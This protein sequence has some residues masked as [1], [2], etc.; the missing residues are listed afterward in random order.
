LEF[1]LFASAIGKDRCFVVVP[2]DVPVESIAPTPSTKRAATKLPSDYLGYNFVAYDVSK[3]KSNEL[4][5]NLSEACAELGGQIQRKKGLGKNQFKGL[6]GN[7]KNAVFVLPDIVAGRIKTSG[8]NP[9]LVSVE[10]RV[11]S[12]DPRTNYRQSWWF[13]WDRKRRTRRVLDNRSEV[14]KNREES[15]VHANDQRAVTAISMVLAKYGVDLLT[16]VDGAEQDT[17]QSLDSICISIG[18]SSG[19][20]YCLCKSIELESSGALQ[21]ALHW[22][23]KDGTPVQEFGATITL[24]S[25]VF[26]LNARDLHAPQ[27]AIIARTMRRYGKN[28]GAPHILCGGLTSV[29]TAVA[30]VFIRHQWRDLVDLYLDNDFSIENDG[31]VAILEYFGDK[32]ELAKPKL[33]LAC[34][35]SDSRPRKVISF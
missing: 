8:K 11:H 14:A 10:T 35:F 27:H 26:G 6:F 23:D 1:G 30:G 34:L 9:T 13:G 18:L 12:M 5:T 2:Q 21:L 19:S 33:K 24:D 17:L 29:G 3:V 25:K 32:C 7:H 22:D 16:T 31:F 4:S 28:K 15:F 20:A